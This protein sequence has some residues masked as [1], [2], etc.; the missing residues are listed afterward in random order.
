MM[1]VRNLQLV[2]GSGLQ[3]LAMLQLAIMR[4]AMVICVKANVMLC[5]NTFGKLAV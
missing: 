4:L 2:N 3:Q 1:V 5:C